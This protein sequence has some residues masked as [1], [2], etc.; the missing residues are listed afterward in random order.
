MKKRSLLIFG[1]LVLVGL[2]WAGCRTSRAGY[3]GPAYEVI[4][5]TDG[6]E[7]R[8][9]ADVVGVVTPTATAGPGDRNSG[10]GRLFR[11]ITGENEGGQKIAM[12]SPVLMEVDR[13]AN[14]IAMIFVMP[15]ET[16]EGGVPSPTRES[17][18]VRTIPGGKFAVLRFQGH[19]SREAQ[20]EALATLREGIARRGWTAQGDPVFAY[21]DPPWTPEFLRRNEVML[22]VSGV[23]E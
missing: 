3:E 8:R 12:T 15:R 14:E 17:V 18:S 23:P 10:F 2:T 11:Y 6:I 4:S 16:V 22:R 19:R 20:L 5:R 7:I 9:Y 1:A 21:Y 13:E